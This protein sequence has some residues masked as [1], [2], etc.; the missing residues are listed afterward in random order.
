MLEIIA[1]VILLNTYGIIFLL[2][3]LISL[4]EKS[5]LAHKQDIA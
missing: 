4:L 5:E 1:F 3:K 2:K